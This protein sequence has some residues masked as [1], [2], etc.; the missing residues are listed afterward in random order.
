[1]ASSRTAVGG[2]G[3]DARKIVQLVV[4]LGA[5][6][7]VPNKIAKTAAAVGAGLTLIALLGDL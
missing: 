6:G 7:F 3:D 4:L 5:L 1:M 2:F